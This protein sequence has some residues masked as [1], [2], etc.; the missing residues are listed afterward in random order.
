ME[1]YEEPYIYI[2]QYLVPVKVIGI[3]L[4]SRE[5]STGHASY[6]MWHGDTWNGNE[7]E[8]QSHR[9]IHL[10]NERYGEVPA[11]NNARLPP[12][13]VAIDDDPKIKIIHV[14][15]Y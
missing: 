4:C 8:H 1:L 11:S 12:H 10:I 13:T 6:V 7:H 2:S 3:R 14:Y 15:K 5:Q 9:D